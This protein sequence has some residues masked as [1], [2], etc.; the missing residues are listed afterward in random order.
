MKKDYELGNVSVTASQIKVLTTITDDILASLEQLAFRFEKNEP[1]AIF[2][3]AY[4]T[5]RCLQQ[6]IELNFIVRGF[7]RDIEEKLD[8]LELPKDK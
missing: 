8:E 3:L 7:A 6:L 4:E 1:Q 2:E 5:N